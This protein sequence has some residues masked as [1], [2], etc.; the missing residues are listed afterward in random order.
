MSEMVSDLEEKTMVSKELGGNDDNKPVEQLVTPKMQ[1]GTLELTPKLREKAKKALLGRFEA[2]KASREARFKIYDR[3]D[4][5]Y[6]ADAGGSDK[7]TLAQ[8][9]TTDGFNIVEDWVSYM[10]DTLFPVDPPFDLEGKKSTITDEQINYIKQVL[11]LNMKQTRYQ[12]EAEDVYRQGVKLGTFV[13][14]ATMTIDDE[15]N[16]RITDKEEVIEYQYETEEGEMLPV[17]ETFP[18]QQIEEYIEVEDHPG[19]KFV[20]LNKLY[21]R[22]DKANWVI[23]LM[24]STWDEVEK[25]S[26]GD[27]K[28]YANLENAK[29]TSYPN[30]PEL[31][32]TKEKEK[33]DGDNFNKNIY[34]L[35]RNLELM[36]G[37]HI[38]VEIEDGKK[39]LCI[40]TMANREEVIRVQPTSYR[41]L[42]YLFTQF[43]KQPGVEGMGYLELV[44]KIL[45]EINTRRTLALDT[46]TMGLYGMKA[47]NMRYIKKPEQLKIR[48]DGVIELK[49]TD[50]PIDQIIQFY[51]PPMEYAAQAEGMLDK[52]AVQLVQTSRMKGILAGEKVT[53]QPSA[54]EWAGM[55]KEAIKSVKLILKRVSE[56][57]IEEWL[58]R[59]YVMNVLNRQK[60]WKIPVKVKTPQGEMQ[61][62]A[63]QEWVEVTPKQLYTDGI[64][65][66]AIG[67]AYME[68][69]IVMRHQQ[70]QKMEI[71]EKYAGMPLIND[72]G[73]PVIPDFYKQLKRLLINFGEDDPDAAFRLAPPPPMPMGPDGQPIPQE[74]PGMPPV[75]MTQQNPPTQGAILGEAAGQGMQGLGM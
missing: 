68:D 52:I 50:K 57:Q 45:R 21:F 72:A 5:L 10:V 14:K 47:V 27:V 66:E 26:K 69:S 33:T 42:P 4:R 16:I 15:P 37:H 48:K 24:D 9:M 3:I 1:F 65:V 73:Q 71:L 30:D 46:N 40:I 54:S 58:E 11:A 63:P 13:S 22:Q 67:I 12:Q 18:S 36:E 8:V 64:D 7:L 44:E 29:K 75:N 51:R 41:Q 28:L 19:Y 53:P 38:P 49:E 74:G 17:T 25:Q 55:M 39:V 61:V 6:R 43:F 70:M 35:D 59:A 56:G 20:N 23:E 2:V 62:M 60:S 32:G 31:Q 34:K